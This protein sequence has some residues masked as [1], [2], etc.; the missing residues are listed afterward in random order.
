MS[1]YQPQKKNKL[2]V[3]LSLLAA[4]AV[5]SAFIYSQKAPAPQATTEKLVVIAYQAIIDPGK[6]AQANHA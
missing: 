6:I 5:I 4:L 2:K 1:L 3:I